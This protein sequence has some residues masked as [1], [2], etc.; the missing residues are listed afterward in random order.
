MLS[1]I[2]EYGKVYRKNDQ[3]LQQANGKEKTKQD[4]EGIVRD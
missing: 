1:L 4:K 3:Y 2:P